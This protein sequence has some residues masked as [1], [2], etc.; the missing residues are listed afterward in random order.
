MNA[1]RLLAMC[2][3]LY[4][5]RTNGEAEVQAYI[6]KHGVGRLHDLLTDTQQNPLS[7]SW[8]DAKVIAAIVSLSTMGLTSEDF[9]DLLRSSSA[10]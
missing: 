8:D 1:Q 4:P 5:S 3:R 6:S 7:A 9:T 2:Q 10:S